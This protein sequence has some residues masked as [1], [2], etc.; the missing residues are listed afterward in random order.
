MV[1]VSMTALA[2]IGTTAAAAMWSATRHISRLD[3]ADVLR[4]DAAD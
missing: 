4:A 3:V 2:I 1:P